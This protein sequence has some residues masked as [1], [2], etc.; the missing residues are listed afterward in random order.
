MCVPCGED[1]SSASADAG[2]EVPV[3]SSVSGDHKSGRT[4]QNRNVVSVSQ[5]EFVSTDFEHE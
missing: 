3:L 5:W 1:V 2:L 4:S